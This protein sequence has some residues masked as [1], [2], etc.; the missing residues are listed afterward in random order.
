MQAW[1]HILLRSVPHGNHL[2]NVKDGIPDVIVLTVTEMRCTAF[3]D[4]AYSKMTVW[5]SAFTL[6]QEYCYRIV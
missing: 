6:T 5:G 2:E 4:P 1:E 3:P